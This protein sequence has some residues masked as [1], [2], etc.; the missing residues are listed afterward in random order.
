MSGMNA[1]LPDHQP[2]EALSSKI[3]AEAETTLRDGFPWLRF[4]SSLEKAFQDNYF[5]NNLTRIR[6]SLLTGILLYAV[7]GLLDWHLIPE[8]KERMW[9][10]RY[11]AVCP[12]GTLMLLFTYVPGFKRYLQATILSSLIF[13]GIGIVAMVAVDPHPERNFYYTGLL[14]VMMYG[15][16]LVGL[17]FWY[18]VAWSLTVLAAYEIVALTIGGTPADAALHNTFCIVAAISIGAVSNYLMEH[19]VRRDFLQGVLLEAEKSQ[20]QEVSRNLERLTVLDELTG[21][22]NRRQFDA[23]LEKEWQR[24]LRAGQPISLVLLDIDCFKAYNDTYGHQAGDL[25]LTSV[26]SRLASLARRPGD[27]A[28]RYGGEEFALVLSG[29]DEESARQI[30]EQARAGVESLGI[31]HGRSTVAPLVTI[32][33]GVAT[34]VPKHVHT[35]K[36]FVECADLALYKAKRDGRNRVVSSLRDSH[37]GDSH[38]NESDCPITPAPFTTTD[39]RE[40]D[41]QSDCPITPVPFARPKGQSLFIE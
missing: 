7:F 36:M 39:H 40:R 26:A 21:I 22:A 27:L 32:S 20:L 24:S 9:L 28:A 16:T 29:T 10:V 14:L 41:S 35:R 2:A 19:F 17:R 5:V 3:V 1:L 37:S 13:G 33:A 18:A 4:P 15:F 34:L 31:P 11:G 38:S 30:A 8:A 6:I 25:C 12:F 23:F